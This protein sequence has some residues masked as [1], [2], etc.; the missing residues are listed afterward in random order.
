MDS[1][2]RMKE[3]RVDWKPEEWPRW[4]RL[5]DSLAW[6]RARLSYPETGAEAGGLPFN[7]GP[8]QD[9]GGAPALAAPGEPHGG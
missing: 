1:D 9:L 3:K 5:Q 6:V 7:Q 4:Q 2:G 8:F